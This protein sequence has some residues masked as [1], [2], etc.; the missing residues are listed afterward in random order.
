M[1]NLSGG[2]QEKQQILTQI[3]SQNEQI[4]QKIPV[5]QPVQKPNHSNYQLMFQG[6]VDD[7]ESHSDAFAKIYENIISG[8]QKDNELLIANLGLPK[9]PFTKTGD[10]L[11]I[12]DMSF[13]P[14][15]DLN[16]GFGEDKK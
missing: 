11:N 13:M 15:F 9:L 4:I 2:R 7:M 16:T 14:N 12:G 5:N 6:M 10:T 1:N 8:K 3:E